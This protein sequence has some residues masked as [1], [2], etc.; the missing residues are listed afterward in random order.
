MCVC[1]CVCV[2]ARTEMGKIAKSYILFV[3]IA[4]LNLLSSDHSMGVVCEAIQ[5]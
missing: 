1:V 2:V 5:K 4:Q 3:S